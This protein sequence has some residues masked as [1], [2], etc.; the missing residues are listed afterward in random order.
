M[1]MKKNTKVAVAF[2]LGIMLVIGVQ[3]YQQSLL[4]DELYNMRYGLHIRLAKKSS[5]FEWSDLSTTTVT[6]L[7]SDGNIVEKMFLSKPATANAREG[8][9]NLYL[10]RW[11]WAEH[12]I[13]V[14]GDDFA[15][16]TF[17]VN[18]RAFKVNDPW[19]ISQSIKIMYDD[20]LASPDFIV[21]IGL[22]R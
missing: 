6:V 10:T 11:V 19:R 9:S 17:K 4:D 14:E 16:F 2:A 21:W 20:W 12:D 5:A 7:D 3:M 22:G 8:K 1:N 18:P 15:T 13:K